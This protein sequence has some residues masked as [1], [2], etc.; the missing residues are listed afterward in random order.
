M[1]ESEGECYERD[2]LLLKNLLRRIVE[3]GVIV[4]RR[5]DDSL[6]INPVRLVEPGELEILRECKP[7]ILDLLAS[8]EFFA[9]KCECGETLAVFDGI[10]FCG[11]RHI[12][13]RFVEKPQ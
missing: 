13:I 12:A 10:G 5:S 3:R 8:G 7:Q 4:D 11:Q 6:G 2:W 9:T 1:I